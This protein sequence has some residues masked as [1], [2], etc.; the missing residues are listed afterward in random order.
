[1]IVLDT[2]ALLDLLVGDPP[3]EGLALRLDEGG[4]LHAPHLIDAGVINALRRLVRLGTLDS[5][6]ADLAVARI[7]EFPILRYPHVHL[8]QRM[9]ELRDSL[10][11][12]D[13]A[14][15]ALAEVLDV[16]LVTTDGRLAG[17]SGHRAA[18]ELFSSP[19]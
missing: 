5:K 17:S 11:A 16:P 15:V 3:P 10:T 8:R 18:I 9:W 1:V 13:A 6:R 2:S 4:S 12:Y 19:S 14:F 7:E